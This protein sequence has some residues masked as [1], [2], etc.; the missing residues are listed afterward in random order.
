MRN[1]VNNFDRNTIESMIQSGI[2]IGIV[3]AG[4]HMPWTTGYAL[5]PAGGPRKMGMVYDKYDRRWYPLPKW[6]PVRKFIGTDGQIISDEEMIRHIQQMN[7]RVGAALRWA[8]EYVGDA[9]W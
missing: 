3:A 9:E 2:I 1:N 6:I 5:N 4:Q 7:E 8:D